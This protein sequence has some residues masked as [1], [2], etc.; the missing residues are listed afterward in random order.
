MSGR[1]MMAL[2]RGLLALGSMVA[3]ALAVA[4]AAADP[5]DCRRVEH[6]GRDYTACT[7]DLT[8]ADLRLF[9]QSPDGRPYGS[10]RAVESDLAG[11]GRALA[12]AMNAG[13]FDDHQRPIGLYIED[14]RRLVDANTRSGYGNFHMKPNGVFYWSGDRAGVMETRQFLAQRP[15]ARFATQSGPMLVIDGSIHPRFLPDSTSR[16]VRNGVGVRDRHTVVFAISDGPVTFHEFATLFRDQLGCDN[17]LFLDGSLSALYAPGFGRT[18]MGSWYG[19]IVGV[20]A[21]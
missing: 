19:P 4:P 2:V 14:G 8:G 7:V 18:G 16:K 12:F 15:A 13:M 1:P 21:P 5:L 9:W 6:R 11:Q 17:A 10:F 20:V 3:A